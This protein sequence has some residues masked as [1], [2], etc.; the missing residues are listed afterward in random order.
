MSDYSRVPWTSKKT[1]SSFIHYKIKWFSHITSTLSLSLLIST[2]VFC[3]INLAEAFDNLIGFTTKISDA[4][5][6][7]EEG[8]EQVEGVSSYGVLLKI[9][10]S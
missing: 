8:I 1:M 9:H 4:K 7:I 6:Y 10:K 3:Y 5:Q 2:S